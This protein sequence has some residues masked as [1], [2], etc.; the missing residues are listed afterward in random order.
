MIVDASLIVAPSSTKNRKGER[1]PEMR[2]TKKGNR[3]Y[4]GMKVPIGVDAQSGLTHSLETTS[5]N[6]SDV[7][8]AHALLHRGGIQLWG[9]AGYRGAGKREENREAAVS[10]P[11]P[12]VREL[13]FAVGTSAVFAFLAGTAE[14]F[15]KTGGLALLLALYALAHR[16]MARLHSRGAVFAKQCLGLSTPACRSRP[17]VATD[18]AKYILEGDEGTCKSRTYREHCG[19]LCTKRSGVTS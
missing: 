7:A 18:A 8:A 9:D 15:T 13:P 4:F 11:S 17:T 5:A 6:A 1:D 14:D 16:R 2:Q 3:W 10:V 19:V 12:P